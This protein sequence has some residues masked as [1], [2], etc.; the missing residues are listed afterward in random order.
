MTPA[1]AFAA[2]RKQYRGTPVLAGIDLSVAPGTCVGLAGLNGAGKSTLLACLLG[3]TRLD[4]GNIAIGGADHLAAGARGPLAYLPERFRPPWYMTGAEWLRWAARVHGVRPAPEATAAVL[5]TLELDAAALARPARQ[6][7]KGMTQKL[8][9]A[10]LALAD[11]PICV[12]D[13]PGAGLDPRARAALGALLAAWRARGRTVLFT[14]HQLDDLA[15]CD[16]LAILHAG[17]L[18]FSGTPQECR[19]R[20]DADSLE[21]AFLRC[22]E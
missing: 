12:L 9:L 7:S 18:R 13:E 3:F 11:K 14:S 1:L 16:Q 2:V 6:Y 19:A 20:Y 15:G 22:L 10:A 4:G 5:A 17:R 21:H 8:G